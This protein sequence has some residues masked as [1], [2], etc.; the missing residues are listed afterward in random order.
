[1]DTFKIYRRRFRLE[2]GEPWHR[3]DGFYGYPAFAVE[4]VLF[5]T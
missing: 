3:F 5:D 1:M 2:D 4:A